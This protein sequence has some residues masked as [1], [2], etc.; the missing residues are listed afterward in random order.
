MKRFLSIRLNILIGIISGLVFILSACGGSG[1]GSPGSQGSENTGA[2]IEISGVNH[3]DAGFGDQGDNW[4]IDYIQDICEDGSGEP[5]GNDFGSFTFK[6]TPLDSSFTPGN[7]HIETY[8][9]EFFPQDPGAPPIERLNGFNSFTIEPTGD[10][11]QS[12]NFMLI[13]VARKVKVAQDVTSGLYSPQRIPILY[14]MRVTFY[15]QDD[16]G[17][18]FSIEFTRTIDLEDFNNC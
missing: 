11:F 4:D 15:G 5:F 14:D 16:F 12:G 1:P 7:L 17:N 3:N 18:D 8:T 6:A 10:E 13:D 2:K 9:V